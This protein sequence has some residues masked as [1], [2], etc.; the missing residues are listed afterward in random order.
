[1]TPDHRQLTLPT[2]P[3]RTEIDLQLAVAEARLAGKPDLARALKTAAHKSR[4]TGGQYAAVG[5]GACIEV[6]LVPPPPPAPRKRKGR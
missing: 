4:H 5:D 2:A 1:M 6:A 3:I